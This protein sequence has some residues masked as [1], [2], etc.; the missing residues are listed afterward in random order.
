[1]IAHRF[2][3]VFSAYDPQLWVLFI[4]W[5]ISSMG[6]AMIV[7]FVSIYFYLELGIPMSVVGG[8]FFFSALIRAGS[9]I[10]AGNL[11]DSIGRRKIMIFAQMVRGAVFFG[12]AVTIQYRLS[13]LITGGILIIGYLFASFFQPVANAMVADIVPVEK[14]TEAYGL[15]KIAANIGWGIGPAAGGLLAKNS[16]ALLFWAGGVLAILSG[17]TIVLFIRESNIYRTGFHYSTFRPKRMLQIFQ[18]RTF[19]QFCIISL[20]MFLTMAQL[21]ATLSVYAKQTIALTNSQLGLMYSTNAFLVVFFQMIVARLVQGR[22]LLLVLASGSILYSIGY[23]LMIFPQSLGGIL[24]LIAVIT[25]AEMLVS[26]ASSTMVARMAATEHYGIYMGA[27]GLFGTLGWSIGPFIGGLL[28][29]YAPDAI[30]L[31]SGVAIFGMIGGV[32]FLWMN[33]RHPELRE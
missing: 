19:V 26:P 24:I 1:M 8:F 28:I 22:N 21:I 29:D 30:T 16:Y 6:F 18:D 27:Y 20:L 5:V 4:G 32:G 31:W 10:I 23:W 13:F 2:R 33:A 9:Q 12:V 14:R 17:I 15:M 3:Q 7:P 25:T 11:S